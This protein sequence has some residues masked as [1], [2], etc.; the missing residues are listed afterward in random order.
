[1]A[2][3]SV[4]VLLVEDEVTVS[5]LIEDMLDELG[6]E[7][8]GSASTIAEA[9]SVLEQESPDCAILDVNLSGVYVYPVAEALRER[10]I[11]YAFSTGYGKAALRKEDVGTPVLQKPFRIDQLASALTEMIHSRA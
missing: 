9:L 11:P 1:M 10:A 5:M 7:V 6:Y 8:V 2:A 4:R 3:R